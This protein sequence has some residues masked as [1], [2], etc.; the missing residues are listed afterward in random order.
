MSTGAGWLAGLQDR[1]EARLPAVVADYIACGAR[2]SSTRDEAPS[3]WSRHRLL[4]HVLTDVTTVDLS[5]GVLGE[6]LPAP[7]AFAPT[8]LQRAVHPDGELAVARATAAVDGL[9]VVSSNAGTT[10]AEIGATGVRWWL[11]VYVTADRSLSVPMLERAVAAGARAIVLT[12]DT[13]VVATKYSA[14]PGVWDVVDPASVR[15]NFDPGHDERPGAAKATDLGPAD[16]AWLAEVTGLPVVV[17]GVL[18]PEDA[19]RCVDAGAAAVWVSNHGGRQLERAVSTASALPGVVEA[20]DGSAEVYVDG[21]VRTGLDVLTALGLGADL[22]LL[23]RPVS[24]ALVEG[25]QGIARLHDA[26]GAELVEAMRLAGT[27]DVPAT[28]GIV[29]R[30]DQVGR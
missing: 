18:R 29:V 13:P 12:V 20:L 2:E 15:I 24:W 16:I 25:E 22:V 11:Q 28:R 9:Q 1:A 21:G 23:G 6:R 10:Y 17:K 4:P 19:R 14:E 27:V 5:T 26:L 3:T 7:W 30:G 8:S